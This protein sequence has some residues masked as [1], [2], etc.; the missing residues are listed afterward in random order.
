SIYS[1]KMP[2][3]PAA[4]LFTGMQMLMG[5]LLL[6]GAGALTGEFARVDPGSISLKSILAVA[7]L[8]VFGAIVGY[9]AYV[10][11]LRVVSPARV[12]TYAYVNPV[13]AVLLGWAFAGES[14]T[15]RMGI[16]AVVIVAGV[17]LITTDSGNGNDKG[18]GAGEGEGMG[19][20][21]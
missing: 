10:W 15:L 13:V 20:G 14:L 12:S 2:A 18:E 11:L 5:G 7:Y 16:A 17:A 1:K 8:I 3:P 4:L 19:G 6:F 21:K 9:T